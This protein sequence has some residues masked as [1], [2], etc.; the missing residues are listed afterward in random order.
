MTARSWGPGL[1]L[2][3]GERLALGGG[4]LWGDVTVV[5]ETDGL[6][7][8][9]HLLGTA[10]LRETG[11]LTGEQEAAPGLDITLDST[12]GWVIVAGDHEVALTVW[13]HLRD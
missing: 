8:G 13:A 10:I 1:V 12:D 2:Q 3:P 11:G 9:A 4:N 6:T 7:L 5:N